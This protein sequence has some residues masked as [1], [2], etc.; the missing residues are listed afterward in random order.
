MSNIGSRFTKVHPFD[1]LVFHDASGQASAV[2]FGDGLR[3]NE[4]TWCDV[5]VF[6][7]FSID[8]L[9]HTFDDEGP[10]VD[11]STGEFHQMVL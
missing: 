9:H 3:E 10:E 7:L 5:E 6:L 11:F 1:I 8:P 2:A 4:R